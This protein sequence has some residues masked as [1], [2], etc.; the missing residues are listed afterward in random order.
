LRQDGWSPLPISFASRARA[1]RWRSAAGRRLVLRMRCCPSPSRQHRTN[2]FRSCTCTAM[3]RRTVTA[4][5]TLTITRPPPTT[6][7]DSI[8]LGTIIKATPRPAL[9]ARCC[10]SRRFL[11]TCRPSP[12][13]RNRPPVAFWRRIAARRTTR[14]RCSTALPLSESDRHATTRRSARKRARACGSSSD[15][16]QSMPAQLGARFA[17]VGSACGRHSRFHFQ[18]LIAIAAMTA[19]LGGCSLAAVPLAG[20]DPADPSAKVARVDYRSTIA[21][22][23]PL[24][25][26]TPAPWRERNQDVAP[27][28]RPDR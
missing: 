25:P 15:Q 28:S 27:P 2:R 21:P 19:C 18:V 14:L 8:R 10:A 17:A 4:R 22:Y 5:S 12:R 13:Q 26:A 9:A 7:P 16:G 20:A 24:R 23:T 3:V 6:R 11:R 1:S